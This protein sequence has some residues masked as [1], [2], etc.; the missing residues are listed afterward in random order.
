MWQFPRLVIATA[1]V[2]MSHWLSIPL[3]S[4]TLEARRESALFIGCFVAMPS[5]M[6]LFGML[7]LPKL[8]EKIGVSRAFKFGILLNLL[9]ASLLYLTNNV[10][11]WLCAASMIGLG[12][13]FFWVA[14]EA[15]LAQIIRDENRGRMIGLVE[16]FI[17]LAMAAAALLVSLINAQFQ[18]GVMLMVGSNLCALLLMTG[19]ADPGSQQEALPEP[20]VPYIDILRLCPLLISA[21]LLGGF[22]EGMAAPMFPLL[23]VAQGMSI[24]HA[25]LLVSLIGLVN[26]VS[27]YPIGHWC[28][29]WHESQVFHICILLA[30]SGALMMVLLPVIWLPCAVALWALGVGAGYTLAIIVA[31]RYFVGAARISAV[32]LALIGYNLG[33]I[34]GPILGGAAMDYF[35][36]MGISLVLILACLLAWPFTRAPTSRCAE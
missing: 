3:Y 9:M 12:N 35:G 21:S 17:G 7:F 14:S 4:L 24:Q 22:S 11:L 36:S 31:G 6:L 28:D 23:G 25:A 8:T 13:G 32:A 15:W 30:V 18:S 1:L 2:V 5:A 16:T 27:Q 34:F 29:R 26:I 10:W 33:C 20:H 19:L